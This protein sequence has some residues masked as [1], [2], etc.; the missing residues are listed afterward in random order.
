MENMLVQMIKMS[1]LEKLWCSNNLLVWSLTT[2]AL[3]GWKRILILSANYFS[4]QGTRLVC[5]ESQFQCKNGR[6]ITLVWRC[7]GDEDCS[8]GSD[9]LNCGKD[10]CSHWISLGN[11]RSLADT[12]MLCL[13]SYSL[14]ASQAE[15]TVTSVIAS[16]SNRLIKAVIHIKGEIRIFIICIYH[17]GWTVLLKSSWHFDTNKQ[18]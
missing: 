6:C 12:D 18:N 9:E 4:I 3:L 10:L 2:Y 1:C 15:Q 14:T 7:D 8:D 13:S 16:S 11:K 5:E 17:V